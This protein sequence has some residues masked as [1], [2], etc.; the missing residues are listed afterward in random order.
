MFKVGDDINTIALLDIDLNDPDATVAVGADFVSG[1]D[2]IELVGF[3]YASPA[4]AFAHVREGA[5]HAEFVDQGTVIVFF[6]LQRSNL[7]TDDFSVNDL[8]MM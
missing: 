1:V 4:E 8:A 6:D 3:G 5:E 7:S 2:L